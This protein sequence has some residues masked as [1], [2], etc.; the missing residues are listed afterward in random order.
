MEEVCPSRLEG[1]GARVEDKGEEST[2]GTRNHAEVKEVQEMSKNVMGPQ[3]EGNYIC[4][5]K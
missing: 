4:R 5:K 2:W 3:K 1:A